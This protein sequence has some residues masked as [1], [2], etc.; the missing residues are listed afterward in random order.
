MVK[1]KAQ[2]YSFEYTSDIITRASEFLEFVNLL[3][4]C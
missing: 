1:L 3:I 4:I 2:L